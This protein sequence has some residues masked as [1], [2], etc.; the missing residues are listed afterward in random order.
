MEKLNSR[1]AVM[2]F[3]LYMR[4]QPCLCFEYQAVNALNGTTI[5]PATAIQNFLGRPHNCVLFNDESH[6]MEEVVV[7]IIRAISCDAQ[8]A[9][10]IM[11]EAHKSGRAIV[12]TTHKER[13][14]QVSMIL[15]QIRLET[16]IEQA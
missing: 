10:A 16:K 4:Y 7:Q 13:C 11:L 2:H 8:R 5:L 14:E 3:L 12:I 9:V 15:E 6:T 1:L